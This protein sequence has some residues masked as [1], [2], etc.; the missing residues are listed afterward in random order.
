MSAKIIDGKA[1][2]ESLRAGIRQRADKFK[3]EFNR[4]PALAVILA[5]ADPASEVYVKNKI[6]GCE[7]CN[8]K[9][10]AYFLPESVTEEELTELILTLNSDASV[11]GI[12]VQ[13]P[14]PKGLDGARVLATIDNRKDVDGFGLEAGGNLFL[15]RRG[16]YACTPAG[17]M[18]LIRSTGVAVEGKHA[19]VVGRSNIVGK[20]AALMLLSQNATVTICHSKTKD[21]ASYTKTADILIAAVGI[22]EFIT[23]DMIKPGA[24]V[25]D[26]GMNRFEGKLF[27]DVHFDSAFKRAG[28]ITPVPGGVGPMTI[29]MLLDNTIKA[30]ENGKK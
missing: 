23:G 26:V 17:C 2:A 14:L 1:I 24:V 7:Q 29:T 16:L 5:G 8:I 4:P 15:G 30:A 27:G 11:D 20:P 18:E 3:A 21:L 12:L 10:L 6:K 9:S 19:V 28:F 13:L 22:K 25:I